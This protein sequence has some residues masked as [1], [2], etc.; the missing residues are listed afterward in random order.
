MI[1]DVA[2]RVR[3]FVVN[4]LNKHPDATAQD[5]RELAR[6]LQS[7]ASKLEKLAKERE[8]SGAAR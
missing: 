2:G 5:V 4:L 3:T 8:K 7:E 6:A 1:A